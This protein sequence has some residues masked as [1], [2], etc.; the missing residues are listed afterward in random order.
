MAGSFTS[1][2]GGG[3]SAQQ[4][5]ANADAQRFLDSLTLTDP[6]LADATLTTEVD[7]LLG[8]EPKHAPQAMARTNAALPDG[9]DDDDDADFGWYSQLLEQAQTRN[10]VDVNDAARRVEVGLLAAE[11]L[12]TIDRT[13]ASRGHLADLHSLVEDG[14][15]AWRWLVLSNLRLVFHWSK[16][17]ARSVDPDWAQDAFQVGCM[18]LI[19]GLQGWDYTLGYKLSTFVSWHIRQAIQ[20]WRANDVMIIRVPVHVWDALGSDAPDLTEKLRQA[21]ARA[22]DLASLE[23]M[24][25]DRGEDAAWDGGLEDLEERIDRERMIHHLLDGLDERST[26]II[27]RRYG[28]GFALGEPMTL[29]EIGIV[30]DVS[31]ER[32]RQLEKKILEALR[33]KTNGEVV[34]PIGSKRARKKKD[35]SKILD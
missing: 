17:V 30:W 10:D 34:D 26:D 7:S 33:A 22:Q 15:E 31:R 19:R 23:A 8:R 21:A 3:T 29:D 9:G 1:P 4:S 11:R 13:T 14:Q 35:R 32:I 6:A 20:R 16:G 2:S 25:L 5:D 12:E 18:G 27:T 24:Y 28:L